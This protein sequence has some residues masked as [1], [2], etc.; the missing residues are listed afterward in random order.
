[1][2][3]AVFALAR[4]A[5]AA[6]SKAQRIWLSD[7]AV[8]HAAGGQGTQFGPSLVRVGRAAVDY[9]LTTGRMPLVGS[10]RSV[11]PGRPRQPLP[12][13][14]PITPSQAQQR[15][16]PA[17]DAATIRELVAFVG[18]LV[19]DGGPAVPV[20]GRGNVARGG[21]LFRENCA[22][23][24]SWSGEGGALLHREEAPPLKA[25]TPVQIAEAMRVG[26]GQM[27]VFGTAALTT[28]Q[29]DD[30]TRYVRYIQHPDDRGGLPFGHVGPVAEGAVG[31]LGLA[32]V[33]WLCVW[34]GDRASTSESSES[35]ESREA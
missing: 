8:C 10:G 33:L 12:G 28:Q 31:L 26:P 11:R 1:M 6:E 16:A 9:E 27:P 34:I 13:I 17:Y 3:L 4:P 14:Q 18:V 2:V 22:A 5:P 25:D 29:L 15:H 21:A 23:C 19:A 20:I 35:S 24:H 30:V 7:C 32:V